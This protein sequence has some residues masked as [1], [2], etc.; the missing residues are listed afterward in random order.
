MRFSE[1]WL[2]ELVSPE[3]S[4]QDLADQ[5]SMAGL[6]VDS[7]EPAASFFENIFIGQ[8][9]DIQVHPDAQKLSVCRVEL[10]EKKIF[11]IV[12][13]AKNIFVGAKV[14]LALED[15]SLPNSVKIK[16]T[17]IRGVD[18]E[19]MI[20]SASELGLAETSEGIYILDLDAPLGENFWDFLKLNDSCI[21]VD[22]T[23]DRGDCL[24]VTGIAREVGAINSLSIK[25]P[26]VTE[27]SND[28]DDTFEV[29]VELPEAC[30]RYL[31]RVIKN[32]NHDAETPCWMIER[33]RR[34]GIRSI[35]P[36]VDITNYV[37]LELGQP[38]HGFDLAKLQG[39]LRIR[40][41]RDKEKLKLLDGENLELKENT[42]IIADDNG[43]LALAGIMGGAET[44]VTEKTKNILL[45]AAF[46][47]P[48]NIAGKARSYALH[49]DSSH[50]FERGV[51]YELPKLAML[52]A[53]EL[54]S[55]IVGGEA[56]P[57]KEISSEA[58]LPKRKSINL[59]LGKI[60]KVLGIQIDANA[61]EDILARLSMEFSKK[62]NEWTVIPPSFRFDIEIEVDLIEEIGRIFGYSNI[63]LSIQQAF[64]KLGS[65]PEVVFDLDKAKQIL[66]GRDFQEAITY[67]FI[68]PEMSSF[69]SQ[70][71]EQIKLANPISSDMSIMRTSILPGI[72]DAI[73]YNRKRQQE[74][75]RLFE[76]GLVF[77][78]LDN[79]IHQID[80]LACAACGPSLPDNWNQKK[81]QID[82]F[83]LKG[84]LMAVL[85]QVGNIDEFSFVAKDNQMFHPGQSAEISFRD[86]KI[87]WLGMLHPK[88]QD[89]MDLPVTF[90][91]EIS[92]D[93][94]SNG[95]LPEFEALSKFPYIKRDLAITVEK[96]I[97]FEEV[98]SVAREAA[99]G[100]VRDIQLFDVYTGEN[101]DSHAKSLALSLILQ[102]S[103]HTLTDKEV[104]ELSALI[105][106]ALEKKLSAKLRI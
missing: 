9:T 104:D 28:V 76:S 55:K 60:K 29:D 13:G 46:F 70:E 72:L 22:L 62:N 52:R 51:D 63:P 41:A 95:K 81:K 103:S 102:E 38:M 43:P 44:A 66:V 92:L 19:G 23:P 96:E 10:S 73:R 16:K 94:I 24:S 5:L 69:V 25:V 93:G 32:I 75:I 106:N 14:P 54:I 6:E 61:V 105:L 68:S 30:P 11:Q 79:K 20:C 2:R 88:I 1:N 83:D 65:A 17:K 7:I 78:S 18:S 58:H 40:Y 57:I 31:C 15:A 100:T 71:S 27:V 77:K 74:R 26:L 12:C 98:L 80:H 90:L 3:V 35:S 49:T 91:F 99:P 36:V 45:E 47:N 89:K 56:G 64:G 101:I 8:I 86:T 84:D 37:L 50:R 39:G 67:S 33:L 48:L 59:R 87:G 53:S 42:L 34:G 97:T 21:E 4:T 82:F 85:S